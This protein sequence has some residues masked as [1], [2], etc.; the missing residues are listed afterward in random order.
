MGHP[1]PCFLSTPLE[2]HFG[3]HGVVHGGLTVVVHGGQQRDSQIRGHVRAAQKAPEADDMQTD[4]HT[5][6]ALYNDDI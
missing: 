1:S 6:R 4:S 5:I 2:S 3:A